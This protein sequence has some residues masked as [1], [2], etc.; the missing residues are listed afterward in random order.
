MNNRPI[1][2]TL[3]SIFQ[4]LMGLVI[5]IFGGGASILY[6]FIGL[7]SLTAFFGVSSEIDVER[8]VLLKYGTV[9]LVGGL[10]GVIGAVGL[11]LMQ[12]WGWFISIFIWMLSLVITVAQIAIG[13]EDLILLGDRGVLPPIPRII[14]DVFLIAY[15][16]M[17]SV[18]RSFKRTHA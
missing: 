13:R 15:L 6:N 2:I 16:L 14:L 3:L 18:R 9:L 17:P 7:A 12:R 11:W 5:G 4:F 10:I 1:G 8:A